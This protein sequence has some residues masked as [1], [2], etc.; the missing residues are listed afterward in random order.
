VSAFATYL[1]ANDAHFPHTAFWD[2]GKMTRKDQR[3]GIG[4][5]RTFLCLKHP[6]KL[7]PVQ[8]GQLPKFVP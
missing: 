7:M 5:A 1:T 6:N 8:P 4:Q 3:L 2:L